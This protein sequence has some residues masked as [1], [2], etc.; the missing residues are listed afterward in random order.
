MMEFYFLNDQLWNLSNF[1]YNKIT[2]K[3]CPSHNEKAN[4]GYQLV[5]FLSG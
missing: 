4:I 2:S 3:Q 5:V 1:N